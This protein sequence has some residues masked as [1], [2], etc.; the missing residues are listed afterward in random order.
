MQ[1][2]TNIEVVCEPDAP[3]LWVVYVDGQ[4]K[5]QHETEDA[6]RA[7]KRALEDSSHVP[8]SVDFGC[9]SLGN[10]GGFYSRLKDES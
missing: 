5:S 3:A 9:G 2:K 1:D 8:T 6:A 4:R 7:A 10:S